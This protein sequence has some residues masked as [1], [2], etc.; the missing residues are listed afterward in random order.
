MKCQA[1]GMQGQSAPWPEI[2]LSPMARC[3]TGAVDQDPWHASQ[4]PRSDSLS[5]DEYGSEHSD[6]AH[7]TN[8]RTPV[9][10]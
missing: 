1:H 2:P 7:A 6:P 10:V 4:D 3:G 5:A 9:S 8:S